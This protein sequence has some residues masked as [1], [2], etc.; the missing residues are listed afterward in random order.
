MIDRAL[1]FLIQSSEA[2]FGAHIKSISFMRL[3]KCCLESISPILIIANVSP[4]ILTMIMIFS[5]SMLALTIWLSQFLN[6]YMIYACISG[7][8]SGI[9][10]KLSLLY[11]FFTI[12]LTTAKH[13]SY[14][15]I[16][17][18]TLASF[19]VIF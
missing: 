15:E 8:I 11:C 13:A 2:L 12:A 5:S 17:L 14:I 7:S 18:P 19:N 1:D 10:L 6:I 16:I 4:Y 3:S 9:W